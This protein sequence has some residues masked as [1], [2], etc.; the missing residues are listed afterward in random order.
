MLAVRRSLILRVRRELRH[1]LRLRVR[2]LSTMLLCESCCGVVASS[3]RVYCHCRRLQRPPRLLLASL[4]WVVHIP[5]REVRQIVQGA[6]YRVVVGDIDVV[7]VLCRQ[8]VSVSP[9]SAA[10]DV[11]RG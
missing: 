11:G 5:T 6:V 9:A 8:A 1:H 3:F 2:D 7:R 4:C 10:V